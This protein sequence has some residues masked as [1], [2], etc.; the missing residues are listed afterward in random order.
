MSDTTASTGAPTPGDVAAKQTAST[1]TGDTQT[2]TDAPA[3]GDAT[4]WKA[5]ARKWEQRAKENKAAAD[6][7][8]KT[9]EQTVADRL[10]AVE[11][12]AAEAEARVLRREIALEHKLTKDDAAL[13]DTITDE[14]A[15]KALAQRLASAAGSDTKHNIVPRE[16]NNTRPG[17]TGSSWGPVLQQLRREQA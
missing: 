7:A 16:G 12:R 15:M 1:A 17:T 2:A 3:Q 6:A 10:A 5:E 14:N 13:L 11:K 4:D 9:A 8:S